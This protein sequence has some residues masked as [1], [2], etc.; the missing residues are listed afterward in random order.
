MQICSS[1]YRKIQSYSAIHTKRNHDQYKHKEG[2]GRCSC[3]DLCKHWFAV[4]GDHGGL[5]TVQCDG[6]VVERLLRVFQYVVQVRDPALKYTS[7]VPRHQG[8]T[9]G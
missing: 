3:S 4:M 6:G 7:E 5:V 1:I 2:F 9:N 8:T